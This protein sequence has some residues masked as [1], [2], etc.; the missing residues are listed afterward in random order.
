MGGGRDM[1][2]AKA[3]DKGRNNQP[4]MGAAKARWRKMEWSEDATTSHLWQR[5][6]SAGNESKRTV[7][8]NGQK[9]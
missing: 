8:C 3:R 9:K 6:A 1:A 2:V 5:Q 7:A 4:S